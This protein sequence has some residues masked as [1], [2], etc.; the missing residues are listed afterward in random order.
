M[1]FNSGFKGLIGY[2]LTLSIYAN[3][4]INVASDDKSLGR[5]RIIKRQV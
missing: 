5:L 2:L 1:G 4:W 3:C